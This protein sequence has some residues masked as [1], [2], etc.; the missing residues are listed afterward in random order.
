[1]RS[2]AAICEQ[3]NVMLPATNGWG[4]AATTTVAKHAFSLSGLDTQSCCEKCWP[5]VRR[6]LSSSCYSSGP[7]QLCLALAGHI[8]TQGMCLTTI[9]RSGGGGGGGG[10][11]YSRSNFPGV[12]VVV[13]H[14]AIIIIIHCHRLRCRRFD[15]VSIQF[16][17]SSPRPQ[18]LPGELEFLSPLRE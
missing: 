8:K 4:A 17:P 1:M 6:R 11:G 9:K 12:D 14:H 5:C 2:W 15:P 18:R 3:R 7:E 16:F 10:S 13:K